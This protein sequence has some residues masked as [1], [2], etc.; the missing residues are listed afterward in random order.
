[1][2]TAY[3]AWIVMAV[4]AIGLGIKDPWFWSVAALLMLFSLAIASKY[5][6]R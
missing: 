1:M 6:H 3:L 5:A 4:L 2:R